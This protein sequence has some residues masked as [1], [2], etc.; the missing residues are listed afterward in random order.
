MV[1]LRWT[2]LGA[3]F[4]ALA[5][6]KIAYALTVNTGIVVGHRWEGKS[7]FSD[8]IRDTNTEVFNK[9]IHHQIEF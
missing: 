2:L 5:C 4:A 8:H 7:L 3:A 1:R 6:A 9:E